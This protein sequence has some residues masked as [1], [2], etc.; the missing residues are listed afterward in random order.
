MK[1]AF[2]FVHFVSSW[3]IPSALRAL[4]HEVDRMRGGTYS[5]AN[6]RG[7]PSAPLRV[8]LPGRAYAAP[9][10]GGARLVKRSDARWM[11]R[12]EAATAHH[13]QGFAAS[14]GAAPAPWRP[15][16]TDV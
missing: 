10:A 2:I 14:R 9:A 4:L 1:G 3:L 12:P 8:M 15:V 16:T 6:K 7:S 13:P 11:R 5:R